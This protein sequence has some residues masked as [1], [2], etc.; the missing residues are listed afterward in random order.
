MKMEIVGDG[1]KNYF[2]EIMLW[3][4][5]CLQKSCV[6]VPTTNVTIFEYW[7]FMGV[8]KIKWSNKGRALIQ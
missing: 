8:M 2:S 3:A 7:V 1:E 4:E 6:E 5:L